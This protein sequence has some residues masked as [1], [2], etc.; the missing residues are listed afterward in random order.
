[1][2]WSIPWNGGKRYPTDSFWQQD[3]HACSQ[4]G[5]LICELVI[6]F[7]KRGVSDTQEPM[8]QL[9]ESK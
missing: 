9:I 3:D 1:M 5:N 8:G 7:R 4:S 2:V 6:R